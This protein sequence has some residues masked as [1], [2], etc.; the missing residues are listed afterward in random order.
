MAKEIVTWCDACMAEDQHSPGHTVVIAVDGKPQSVDLCTSHDDQL[1]K[2]LRVLM[3][4][5]GAPV[6][7]PAQSRPK[8]GAKVS[9]GTAGNQHE[10]NV[11]MHQQTGVRK[12]KPPAGDR[13]NQ[14]LWCPLTYSGSASSGFGRHLRVVHG[15][16]GLREAF[17]GICPVCGEG[18]YEM[19]GAHV[20]RSHKDMGFE[21]ASAPYTWA[22]D[23]GDPHGVYAAKLVQPPSLDP[24]EEWERTRRQERITNE[25]KDPELADA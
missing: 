11:L 14:C 17:G 1:V 13:S 23:N 10:R 12:G 15:F 6:E 4:E 20:Q 8:T 19:M 18:P 7:L 5:F 25:G 9:P 24:K 16:D 2:P 22:R 21:S 3:E